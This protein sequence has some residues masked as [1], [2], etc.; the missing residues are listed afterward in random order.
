MV[1]SFDQ[2]TIPSGSYI[3][4]RDIDWSEFERIL[5]GL[6]HQPGH[7]IAYEDGFLEI[8]TP[9][10]EHE[11]FKELLSDAIKEVAD[12]LDLDYASYGSTTWRSRFKQAG[13]E[14][15]NCFYIKNEVMIRGKLEFDLSVDPPPDLA[16][17]IDLTSPSL[18][19]FPIYARLG[20]PEIWRYAKGELQVYELQGDHYQARSTSLAFPQLPVSELPT[21]LER[22]RSSGQRAMRR[23]VRDWVAQWRSP[24]ATSDPGTV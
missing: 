7:R 5:E 13:I 22:S 3:L 14:P 8:M 2:L 1:V 15:D 19:R 18:D 17:E 9:L 12:S 6:K 4:L 21:V 24:Q 20:I 11:H 10:P 16:L 23:A